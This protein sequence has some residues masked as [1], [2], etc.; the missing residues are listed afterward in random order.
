MPDK[1]QDE[2]IELQNDSSVKDAFDEKPIEEFWPTVVNS[3]PKIAENALHTLLPFV[4]TYLCESGFSTMVIIKSKQR[5]RLGLE[6]GIRCALSN[7]QPRIQQ[8]AKNKKQ[9]QSH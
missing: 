9:H 3:Y 4:S 8:L 7:I 2:L 1:L 6:D 5:N